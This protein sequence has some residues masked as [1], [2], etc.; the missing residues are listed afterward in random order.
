[1]SLQNCL[2]ISSCQGNSAVSFISFMT[3]PGGHEAG[4]LCLGRVSGDVVL[5]VHPQV[6]LPPWPL[7]R[8]L[9][10]QALA[11]DE[12]R[13]HSG[14][15]AFPGADLLR[16]VVVRGVNLAEGAAPRRVAD[17]LV[18]GRALAAAHDPGAVCQDAD[19]SG[20]QGGHGVQINGRLA[21]VDH[22]IGGCRGDKLQVGA[23]VVKGRA[24]GVDLDSRD[25]GIVGF[26]RVD[27]LGYQVVQ[28]VRDGLLGHL[29]QPDQ[30]HPLHVL[31]AHAVV[32]QSP[33]EALL[34]N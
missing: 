20:C 29:G 33:R 34:E 24:P 19:L 32:P 9:W 6:A 1:M 12:F 16:A 10:S 30:V 26:L 21:A 11:L 3:P 15:L 18:L 7:A 8:D 5:L 4:V 28:V 23:F 17:K 2:V 13:V 14:H 31:V 25:D 22:D 27:G